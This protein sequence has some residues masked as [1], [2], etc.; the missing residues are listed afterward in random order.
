[1]SREPQ[2]YVSTVLRVPPDIPLAIMDGAI[3]ALLIMGGNARANGPSFMTAR[4]LAPIQAWGC[5]FIALSLVLALAL[6]L[7][8]RHGLA[9]AVRIFGPSLCVM[10][11]CMY[12][13]SGLANHSA[14]FI[15]VPPYLYLAYRHSFAPARP[16]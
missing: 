15:G 2:H 14:S 16:A 1:M 4:G 13:L 5:A 6:V 12:L 7:P 10:W 11:A 8:Q 3:G 9:S